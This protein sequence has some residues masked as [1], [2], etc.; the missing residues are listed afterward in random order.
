MGITDTSVPALNESIP[1]SENDYTEFI[2]D[3]KN[4][5]FSKDCSTCCVGVIDIVG[6]T[7]IAAH[8]DREKVSK[9]YSL[10]INWTAA[11]VRGFCGKVVKNTGDGLLFYFASEQRPGDIKTIQQCLDCSIVLSQ[12]HDA[13]NAKFRAESL[14]SIDYR[15]SLDYGEVYFAKMLG[16]SDPDIFG[17]T[18]NIC[19]KI[20]GLAFPNTIVVGGDLYRVSRDFNRYIFHETKSILSIG[21]QPYPV[22]T[23]FEATAMDTIRHSG[24]TGPN[25]KSSAS[26]IRRKER[27][28]R[29]L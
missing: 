13:V 6:S 5:I 25:Q 22:Y 8:L 28:R 26:E 10:F 11:V 29:L 3:A 14:P 20:N 17:T 2:E 4:I 15:I 23:L 24:S 27:L 1:V 9:Y 19:T 16:S 7:R 18:V 12:L 21:T